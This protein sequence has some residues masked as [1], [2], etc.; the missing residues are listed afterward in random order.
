[1]SPKT[2]TCF[3]AKLAFGVNIRNR[4]KAKIVGTILFKV[5]RSDM[6]VHTYKS[7]QKSNCDVGIDIFKDIPD[8]NLIIY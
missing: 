7:M 5:G 8:S 6:D 2:G 4:V 1:M 3:A